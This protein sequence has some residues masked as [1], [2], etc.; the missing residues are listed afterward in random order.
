MTLAITIG[1]IVPPLLFQGSLLIEKLEIPPVLKQSFNQYNLQDLEIF[2]R[3]LGSLPRVASAVG[4]TFSS[5]LLLV[6]F[7]VISYY[8]LLE[9]PNLHHYLIDF[10]GQNRDEKQIETFISRVQVQVGSWVRGQLTLMLIV[11][12][13]TYTGLASLGV[14]YALPLAMLAGLLEL[15]P[16]IGPT[17]AAVPAIFVGGLS[18]G[19]LMAVAVTV[20]YILIQQLEN[21]LL[22]PQIMRKAVGIH[23]LV[24]IIL[25]L[26]GLEL[27]SVVGAVLAI[28]VFLTL[29]VAY[30]EWS[31]LKH[32]GEAITQVF[33]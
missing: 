4:A 27:K 18:H 19:S 30:R 17:I 29:K 8:L 14:P 1:M 28:P 10:F 20:L 22:V 7:S 5:I 9:L 13:A 12:L 31:K 6:T 15:I 2:T 25:I 16:N 33:K 32:P 24:T 3:Q 23:P 26:I 21:I 11:G